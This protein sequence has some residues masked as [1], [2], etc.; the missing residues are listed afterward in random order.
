VGTLTLL[1]DHHVRQLNDR[2]VHMQHNH[3]EQIVSTLHVHLDHTNCLEVVILR[4]SGGRY[5]AYRR[6][7]DCD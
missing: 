4:G 3:Y 7:T 1:Y 6:L 5:S 2:L